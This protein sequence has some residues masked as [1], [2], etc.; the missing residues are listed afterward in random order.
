M[1]KLI[2]SQLV[3]LS[4]AAQR[5]DRAILPL[6]KSVKLNKGAATLVLKS[7]L[8]QRFVGERP[9][10]RDDE[11]WRRAEDGHSIAFAITDLG[12]QAIGAEARPAAKAPLPASPPANQKRKRAARAPAGSKPSRGRAKP[13]AR[14]GTKLALLIDLL[15]RKGAHAIIVIARPQN[16][17]RACRVRSTR[18][19]PEPHHE[20]QRQRKGPRIGPERAD[21]PFSALRLRDPCR[22]ESPQTRENPPARSNLSRYMS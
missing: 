16:M 9:P 6:P 21:T 7:L 15:G 10:D 13:A 1:P 17:H 20:I 3:I 8:R 14:P 22:G 19:T 18:P 2:D 12:L 11:T 5:L 4:A